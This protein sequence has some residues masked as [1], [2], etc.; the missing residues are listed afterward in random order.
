MEIIIE[1]VCILWTLNRFRVISAIK[2]NWKNNESVATT[3]TTMRRQEKIPIFSHPSKIIRTHRTK[4]WLRKQANE[5]SENGIN[6]AFR[7]SSL[8]RAK[9]KKTIASFPR[10]YGFHRKKIIWW[11]IIIKLSECTN[12][13]LWCEFSKQHYIHIDTHI[14]FC[15]CAMK[16]KRLSMSIL[17]LPRKKHSNSKRT[18]RQKV[19]I[20]KENYV[21]LFLHGD[22]LIGLF[23]LGSEWKLTTHVLTYPGNEQMIFV[24][25]SRA[26]C[27]DI[28]VNVDRRV[29]NAGASEQNSKKSRN[30]DKWKSD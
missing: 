10:C 8:T 18:H 17:R 21:E 24:F 9:T 4:S 22:K 1:K 26:S 20:S 23:G 25:A 27:N 16:E 3:T 5:A 6:S 28:I 29:M 13:S 15:N 19:K 30:S 2:S 14:Y 7:F 11:W 12:Q